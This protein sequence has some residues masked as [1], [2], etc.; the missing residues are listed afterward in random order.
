MKREELKNEHLKGFYDAFEKSV[1]DLGYEEQ[2]QAFA[3]E[4]IVPYVQ[5]CEAVG[6]GPKA[7]SFLAFMFSVG[8]VSSEVGFRRGCDATGILYEE[9]ES[10]ATE[11]QG[12]K[13]NS[14]EGE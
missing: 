3:E 2:A 6:G 1:A 4:A 9:L 5:V 8:Q 11:A 10:R 7:G 14:E 12:E 13:N